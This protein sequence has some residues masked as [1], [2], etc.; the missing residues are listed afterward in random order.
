MWQ[1]SDGFALIVQP[2]LVDAAA[3]RKDRNRYVN[4]IF[5][6]SDVKKRDADVA[7]HRAFELRISDD[8]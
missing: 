3:W 5:G 8:R 1:S 4:S 7:I 2:L 6:D